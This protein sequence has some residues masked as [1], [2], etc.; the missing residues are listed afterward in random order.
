MSTNS[1]QVIDGTVRSIQE[2]FTSRSYAIEYYQREYS[3]SRTNIEEL[4]LDLTRSFNNDYEETHE[5]IDV[6]SYRPYFLGPVVTFSTKGVRFLVDGQQRMTSLSLLM[7]YISSE[8]EAGDSQ[9]Q[10]HNLIYSTQY[11]KTKFTIDVP[12]RELVMTAV[13]KGD[14][15]PPNELDQSSEVIWE[16]YNDIKNIFPEELMGAVL[17]Y[18]VDWLLHRVVLVDIGTTDKDMALEIFESMND[19]GLQLSNMDMLKSYLL[20]RISYPDD[21]ERANLVWRETT[22]SLKNYDKNG[23]SDFMKSMLRAKYAET[24]R[25]TKKSSG[26]KDFEEIATTFHKWTRDKADLIGLAKPADFLKFVTGDLTYFAKRY[27]DLLEASQEQRP[28]LDY[29]YYNAHNDFT[30]QYMVILAGI[31]VGDSDE[32]FARKANLIAAYIDIMITRRMAEYKNFGYSPMYRPM[33]T[34]AKELR[35]K[36]LE[37]IRD[38]LKDKTTEL[39]ENLDSLKRLRLTKTNKPDIY[40]I[41]ARLTSWLGD[42]A[43]ALYLSRKR[44]DPFEVEHIWANKFERHVDEFSNEYEFAEMRNSLGDLV[45]LKKSFNASYGAAE[46]REKFEHYFGQNPLAKSLHERNYKNDPNFARKMKENNLPFKPYGPDE[47]KR[48]A[49]EERQNLYTQMAEIIWSPDVLDR[50]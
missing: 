28:G 47:F 17:P 45:L 19:R 33:F 46:Y 36:S 16:R 23:D 42:E 35:N 37:E 14:E 1:F 41:L 44:N 50:I 21:I 39:N 43:T 15:N 24:M 10:L 3:W 29:V 18:F 22:Q 4:I 40:Y 49:I 8:L 2:M 38:V 32:V 13:R 11:G 48:S 12:E 31:V 25:D 26:A 30:L 5:R 9:T 6:A 27:Q 34:L 7:S 20:S